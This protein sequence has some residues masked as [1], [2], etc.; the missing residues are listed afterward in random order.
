MPQ[1]REDMHPPREHNPMG[2]PTWPL[3]SFVPFSMTCDR[4]RARAIPRRARLSGLLG[5]KSA[6]RHPLAIRLRCF[7]LHIATTR[8]M[9]VARS[10]SRRPEELDEHPT[11]RR[12]RVDRFGADRKATRAP[13]S[14][15]P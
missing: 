2:E 3:S 10:N 15:S 9:M 7:S 6:G 1:P 11:G 5:R 8:S 14:S 12:G 4:L 13:S